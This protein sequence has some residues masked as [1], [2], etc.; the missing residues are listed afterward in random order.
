MSPGARQT[1]VVVLCLTC[2]LPIFACGG[3]RPPGLGV[4]DGRLAPCPSSPNCVSSDAT[5]AAHRV[6]AFVLAGPPDDAWRII[7]N[8]VASLPR[9]VVVEETD[10]Y[11]H[12]ECTSRLF[13]FVDDLELHLGDSGNRVAIRSAS[14]VGYSDVGVNR[15]RI[16]RLRAA[17]EARGVL[18]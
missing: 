1:R 9:T 10:E 2:L 18:D 8:E 6:E 16:E 17:L 5:D 12:A 13:R 7:R 15:R 3:K 11:I 4:S 14:R